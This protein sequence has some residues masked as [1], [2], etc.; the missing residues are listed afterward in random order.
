MKYDAY[1]YDIN[2]AA[3]FQRFFVGY[4]HLR[5]GKHRWGQAGDN[6]SSESRQVRSP[7][8]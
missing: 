2:A 4:N 6:T 5:P 3:F 1:V 7:I 8:R